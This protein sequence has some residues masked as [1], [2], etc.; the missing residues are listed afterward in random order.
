MTKK[1]KVCVVVTARPSYS[2]VKTALQAIKDHPD[3]ELQL[4]VAA[5]AVL[6][7]Y[8]NVIEQITSDGFEINEKVFMVLEGE[9]PTSMAKTTGLGVLELATTFSNLEPDIVVTIADRFETMAT[10]LAG[11]YMNLSLIHI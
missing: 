6:K 4:V 7:R 10:A 5:S 11:A 8:G 3:L 9:N 1:R 2:R